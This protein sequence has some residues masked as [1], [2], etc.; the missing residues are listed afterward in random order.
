M[1]TYAIPMIPGPT[2]IPPE[3]LAVYQTNFGSADLE[4][5]FFELYAETQAN[6]QELLLTKNAIAMMSGEGMLALWGALKS[7]LKPGDTVLAL[8]NGIFGAGVG[9]MAAQI[10]A[11][12]KTVNFPFDES[13]DPGQVEKALKAFRPKMVTAIHCETPSGMLNPLESIG[14]LVREYAVPLFY[15]DA[16]SSA[17]GAAVAVDDWSID[18]GL[19][20]SQKC[21]S[22]L[23][24][25]AIVTISE[26]AWR[27]IDE[28]NYAGYDALKPWR[29][30]LEDRYFPYTPSWHDTA[31]LNAAC[32]LIL[33]EGLDKVISRHAA[34]AAYCRMRLQELGYR[35][36]PRREKD[37]SPT[38]TAAL[39]PEKYTWKE[40]DG[41]LRERGLAVGGSYGELAGKVFRLG[42][43]GNQARQGLVERALEV[44]AA[45]R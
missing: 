41:R 13:L 28:V 9:E 33:E 5:E 21:L 31:A 17:A 24:N 15:V 32:R 19:A 23:P 7:C 34:V 30:A 20:G 29:T 27:V 11:E 22:S 39:V 26:R 44:L 42:H 45:V 35:L 3:V 38:V 4:P 6:L 43:M 14:R 36:Y 37:C 8:S 2:S 10:G 16:V 40:F 12:V 1:K 18:L 25:M